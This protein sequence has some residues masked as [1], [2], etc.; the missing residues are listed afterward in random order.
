MTRQ[1][2]AWDMPLEAVWAFCEDHADAAK[3]GGTNTALLAVTA[4]ASNSLPAPWDGWVTITMPAG[5]LACF[6]IAGAAAAVATDPYLIGGTEKTRPI[7]Q[8]QRVSLFA[9][10]PATFTASITMVKRGYK[11]A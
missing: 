5:T 6:R 3:M 4:A 1:A 10:S 9:V 2:F 8:G 11:P 7:L